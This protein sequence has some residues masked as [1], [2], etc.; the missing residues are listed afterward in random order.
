MRRKK[1]FLL[2]T[3]RQLNGGAILC[4]GGFLLYLGA[5]ALAWAAVSDA[6][7][8]IFF[9]ASVYVFASALAGR[10]RDR[11]AVSYSLLWGTAALALLLGLCAAL[12]V[13]LRLGL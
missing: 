6:L 4:G 1:G 11:E 9:L 13:K 5:R 2:Q 3:V 8:L 12:T 10:R 7:A